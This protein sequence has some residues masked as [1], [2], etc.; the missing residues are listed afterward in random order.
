VIG[1]GMM[2]W[3]TAAFTLCIDIGTL[4]NKGPHDLF[5]GTSKWI[6]FGSNV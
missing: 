2:Q 1:S 3:R 4:K 5:I 6:V